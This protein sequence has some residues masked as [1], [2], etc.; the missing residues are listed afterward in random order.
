MKEDR[1]YKN[2][3]AVFFY[4]LRF[5]THLRCKIIFPENPADFLCETPGLC[6]IMYCD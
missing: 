6:A 3:R 4:F 1:P 5:E 2:V